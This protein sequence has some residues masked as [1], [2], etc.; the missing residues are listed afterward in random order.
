MNMKL[1]RPDMSHKDSVM[2]YKK[3][4]LDN[5][6]SFDGCAG[7]EDCDTYEMWL[8]FD[9]RLKAKYG[10]GYVKSDTYIAIDENDEV[11]GII[12]YRKELSPFLL[13]YGGNIGYSIRPSKRRCGYA[14]EMLKELLSILKHNN[15]PKVL[16][17]CDKENE[18]SRKTIIANGGIL[19][20]EI[21][22]DIGLSV[23]GIIQRYWITL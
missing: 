8:D 4:M 16:L 17:T 10:D 11:I 19:E 6:D 9:N 23:S 14:K 7:L 5:H 22:D 18:A 20:N 2:S 15:I 1:I 12:D 13:K 21:I 3:E